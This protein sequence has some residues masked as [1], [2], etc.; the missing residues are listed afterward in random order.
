[1]RLFKFGWWEERYTLRIFILPPRCISLG[2]YIFYA[3][4]PP[5]AKACSAKWVDDSNYNKTTGPPKNIYVGVSRPPHAYSARKYDLLYIWL[6]IITINNISLFQRNSQVCKLTHVIVDWPIELGKVLVKVDDSFHP[7][8]PQQHWS[9]FRQG[10]H[11]F[12]PIIGGKAT[13]QV[14]KNLAA[15]YLVYDHP[16][17]SMVTCHNPFRPSQQHP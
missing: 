12:N 1:M 9:S 5:D 8:S 10:L 2:P 13:R 16:R 14:G 4:S 15:S 17:S 3:P 6:R 11:I 7:P